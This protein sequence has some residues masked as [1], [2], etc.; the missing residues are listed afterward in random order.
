M[1]KIIIT[2]LLIVKLLIVNCYA[3]EQAGQDIVVLKAGVGARP[4]GMG[5]AFTAV[6]DNADACYWNPGALGFIDHNEITSMQTKLSTDADHYY[7]SYVRPAFGGT[8]GISWIQVGLGDISNTSQEVDSNNEVVNLG[9][10]NYFANAYTV[11]YGKKINDNV[12]FGLSAKYL[13]S[14]MSQISGGQATGYSITPGILIKPSVV[15]SLPLSIG[16]KIDDFLNSQTWGTGTVEKVSPK[17]RLGL[18]VDRL[19][20]ADSQLAVDISQALKSGYGAEASVGYEWIRDGLSFR[21]GYDEGLTAGTGFESGHTR[22]D[23]AYV[24]QNDLSVNNVH[25]VSLTGKW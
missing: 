13:T 6:C 18:A 2:L 21:V 17:L 5:S 12:S 11:A 24:Q 10:F 22:V 20:L 1:N 23:Y 14:D 9:T 8:M 7:I 15:S 25:R 19:P 3:L 16:L 4:L